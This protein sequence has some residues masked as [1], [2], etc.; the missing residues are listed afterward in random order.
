MIDFKT[1]MNKAVNNFKAEEDMQK[2][3]T[4]EGRY[5]VI[6]EPNSF[7]YEIPLDECSTVW[8]ALEW[9]MHM[10]EKNWVTEKKL[11]RIAGLMSRYAK[12]QHTASMI[13][14]SEDN[15]L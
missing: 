1:A 3:I 9:I 6:R 10:M 2:N 8:G 4:I 15:G 11:N 12:D 5:I 13:K 7:V 14:R